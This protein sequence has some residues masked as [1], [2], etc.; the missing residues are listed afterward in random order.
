M[1]KGTNQKLKLYYLA[2]IMVK[3]TDDEHFLTMPQIKERLEECGITADRKSLYDDMEALRT[4]G[5]DV[6]LEQVGRNYYYHVGSKHFEIAE[7][8]LLVD[9]IQSSKFIT[10]KKSNELIK[11][12]TGLV[13]EYEAMQLKRQ[14]EVQGRIKTMNESIYYIVD[15]IHTA[16]S[17]NRRIQ[18]EYLKWNLNKE[19]VPRK[20]GLYEVSPWA[21][22]WDDE[23][24]YLIAFDAEADKIKHY[25]VDK[26]RNIRIMDDR[27]LGKE[28]FKAFDMAS[29]SKMNFGMFGGTETKVKLKFKNDLV[30]VLIDRFGKDISIRKSDEEGW[31]ETSVDVAISDQFFGWLFALS[32]GVIIASPEDVKDR[33]RQELLK[34]TEKYS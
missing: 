7:L 4:L 25:R 33:Y 20:E 3:M 14:V 8:K 23:N 32:D 34:I 21:L 2:K 30:G 13:S 24:Y 5:I 28:H 15:E 19:L 27:R 18:F 10:E 11:K 6:I 26:M 22:T 1:P 17:T 29:Y 12:L 9:A 16:I 31:S